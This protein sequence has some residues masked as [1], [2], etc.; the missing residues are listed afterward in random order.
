MP[1]PLI[2]VGGYQCPQDTC[3]NIK[4]GLLVLRRNG[5]LIFNNGDEDDRRDLHDIAYHNDIQ[6]IRAH[7]YQVILI[8]KH[9]ARTF[10]VNG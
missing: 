1:K 7:D 4:K 10:I 3:D 8:D 9:K 5:V 2:D 6:F